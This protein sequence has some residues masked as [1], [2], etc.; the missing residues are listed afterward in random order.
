MCKL[1]NLQVLEAKNAICVWR[2]DT[3]DD[4]FSGIEKETAEGEYIVPNYYIVGTFDDG[5]VQTAGITD[6]GHFN[7]E[8]PDRY[9]VF[10]QFL[11]KVDLYVAKC[12][13]RGSC[14]YSTRTINNA[15]EAI[16]ADMMQAGVNITDKAMKYLKSKD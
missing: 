14:S 12:F 9:F 5:S 15:K 10:N 8:D 7:R 11:Y 4:F 2:G 16:L 3:D 6:L 13:V 1:I